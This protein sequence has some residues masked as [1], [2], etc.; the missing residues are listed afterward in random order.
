[1][2]AC[3][4]RVLKAETARPPS[5]TRRAQ[6]RRT[7]RWVIR[8]NH[9]R[10]HEGLQLRRPGDVYRAGRR[11]RVVQRPVVKYRGAWAQ[12][13]VRSN[14]EIKWQGRLRFMGE[15]FIGYA[16]GLKPTTAGHWQIY[17]AGL[18]VGELRAADAGGLRPTAYIPRHPSRP[19][20]KV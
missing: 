11:Q 20:R 14:G 10:P 8:Y 4:S 17:F 3:P 2:V 7:K 6:Q 19:N 16:V 9:E 1:M 18:K 5:T 12:R 13:K 15:A